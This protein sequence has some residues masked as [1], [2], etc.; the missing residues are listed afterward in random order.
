MKFKLSIMVACLLLVLSY[1]NNTT[2]AQSMS[3]NKGNLSSGVYVQGKISSS[4]STDTY[5]FSTSKDGEVYITLDRTTA[6]FAAG[7]YDKNGKQVAYKS[8]STKGKDIVLKEEVKKGTYYV[9]VSPLGWSGVSRATYRLKSTYAGSIKRNTS[10]FEPNETVETSMKVNSGQIYKSTAE[11]SIDRD[12]YQFT[13]NKDGEVYIS[14]DQT[15]AGFAVGLYNTNGK[16]IAYKSFSTKGKDIVLKEEIKKG[17]YYIKVSPLGWSGVSSATYRL[18]STYAG[19]IKR[20]NSTF[21]PNETVETSMNVNSGQ[22]YKSTAESAVDR[23]VYQ[24]TMKK[25]GEVNV[26]V[27]QTTAGFAVGLYSIDGKQVAYKSFS[28]KGKNIIL[29]KE[30]KKGTYY[31]KVSPLGWYGISSATYRLTAKYSTSMKN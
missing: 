14:L 20:N 23:D 28:T 8:F 15:T 13:T 1:F 12:V 11:T 27:D 21:E 3:P 30:V 6:G 2:Y 9:K 4:K 29:K 5:K 24:F 16:Q 10:T 19:S 22:I 31:V 7:L 17:T 25:D 26:T 18:K